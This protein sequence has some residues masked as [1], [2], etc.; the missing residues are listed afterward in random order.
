MCGFVIAYF[1]VIA[2]VATT[3]ATWAYATCLHPSFYMPASGNGSDELQ[4]VPEHRDGYAEYAGPLG[5]GAHG[6]PVCGSNPGR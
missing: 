1:T 6:A 2:P 4:L 5:S 3:H